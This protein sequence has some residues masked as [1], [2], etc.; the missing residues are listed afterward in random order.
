M[1]KS[2]STLYY[3]VRF[4]INNIKQILK[5]I[6]D[7]YFRQY[8][9]SLPQDDPYLEQRNNELSEKL[10]SYRYNLMGPG[11]VM[12]VLI[13]HFIDNIIIHFVNPTNLLLIDKKPSRR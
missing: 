11:L 4:L 13:N 2:W 10:S 3:K 7:Q 12:Q 1:A 8:D 9:T 6:F 5:T